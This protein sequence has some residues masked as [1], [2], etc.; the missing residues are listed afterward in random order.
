MEKIIM[1]TQKDNAQVSVVVDT[2][3]KKGPRTKDTKVIFHHKDKQPKTDKYCYLT[4]K[5]AG[6]T[7]Y[8]MVKH[9]FA[10]NIKITEE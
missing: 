4:A 7:F 8:N 3:K 2:E 5:Q 1:F 9:L 10:G 6:V